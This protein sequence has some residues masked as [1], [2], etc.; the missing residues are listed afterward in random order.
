MKN[1]HIFWLAFWLLSVA[2][3]AHTLG[4]FIESGIA[5]I[6]FKEYWF[7]FLTAFVLSYGSFRRRYWKTAR[8][9]LT[10]F[11]F[12]QYDMWYV[13]VVFIAGI[14]IGD[15]MLTPLL[16]TIFAGASCGT[17]FARCMSERKASGLIIA[18]IGM[19]SGCKEF[20]LHNLAGFERGGIAH[21]RTTSPFLNIVHLSKG[22]YRD[23]LLSL[24][25]PDGH[26]SVTLREVGIILNRIQIF[27]KEY[28]F[29]CEYH[30]DFLA[31]RGGI[32]E[33]NMVALERR[34]MS[35]W[36]FIDYTPIQKQTATE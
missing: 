31:S 34:F 25:T 21:H 5:E 10:T 27:L 12:Q 19:E 22:N 32:T 20:V 23:L 1:R 14:W 11:D 4:N 15:I 18:F 35:R 9:L 28:R 16:M 29:L 36:P 26:E 8:P 30:K 24:E 6:L 33:E 17:A 3:T 2:A 13:A 7:P